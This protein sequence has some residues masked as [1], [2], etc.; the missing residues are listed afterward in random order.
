[1]KLLLLPG[2]NSL[3]HI[4]KCLIIKNCLE[5]KGHKVVITS[6]AARSS[7]LKNI[8][9]AHYVLPDIQ[10]VDN[11]PLP[12][13]NWFRQPRKIVA[14]ILA[15]ADLIKKENPDRIIGV[16]RFTAKASAQL[17]DIPYD[18]LICGCMT[19]DFN[20][21]LGYD[22]NETGYLRQGEFLNNFYCYAAEKMNR[23]FRTMQV[24]T[25]DDMRDLFKGEH[26]FLWD[27][28]EFLPLPPQPDLTYLGPFF[29]E[30]R[31]YDL[32]DIYKIINDNN[33]LAI[34]SFGTGDVSSKIVH[35]IIKILLK[36]RYSVLL[37]AGGHAE[38]LKT[39]P[40]THR[41][42]KY[43]FVPL[44]HILPY[45]SLMISHGGQM[46]IFESLLHKVPVV[47]MPLQPEQLHNGLCLERTGCGCRLVIPEPFRGDGNVYTKALYDTCDSDI[48]AKI[49]ELTTS[50][51]ISICLEKMSAKIKE[52]NSA[53]N[54]AKMIEN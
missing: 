3:S 4:I 23:V 2:N 29:W 34:V 12:T 10:Q 1:M 22:E 13:I 44:H 45:A 5:S 37:A 31:P 8:G 50:P 24:H 32:P 25:I 33:P 15:E 19:P 40:D 20:Q 30:K 18:S 41:L 7:F 14:S 46:T 38:L 36:M 11:A 9:I 53:E 6:S 47:V 52:Y 48:E 17:T 49:L 35:R 42:Y 54:L 51:R 43:L 27:F 26:T 28:P 39:I 21:V 16:F